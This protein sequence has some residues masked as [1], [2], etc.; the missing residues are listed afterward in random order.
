MNAPALI[1]R[2]KAARV[3]VAAAESCTGGQIASRLT[4]VPGSSEVFWGG[5]VVYDN[6]AKISQLGVPSELIATHGAVSPEVAR[7]LA[8]GGLRAMEQAVAS[9]AKASSVGSARRSLCVA[10]TGIAGPGGGS[11]EKPVG[12]CYVGIAATDTGAVVREVRLAPGQDRQANQLAFASAAFEEIEKL[13][14]LWEKEKS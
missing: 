8:E 14:T 7:A 9:R 2:L 5:W 3:R 12:L 11:A 4:Q 13:L 6:T 10:T 1:P